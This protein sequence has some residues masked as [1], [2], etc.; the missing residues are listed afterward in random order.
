MRPSTTLAWDA[1]SDP[2]VAGYKIYWR[3]TTESQWQ[4]SRWVGDVTEFTLENV[5]IDNFLFG[6]AAVGRDGNVS[7]VAFPTSLLRR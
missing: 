6:V 7:P 1:V 3:L 2:N 5:V 4:W